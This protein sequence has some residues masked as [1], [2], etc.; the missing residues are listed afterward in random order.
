[1]EDT[2]NN[3]NFHDMDFE[4]INEFCYQKFN[5][6]S[7]DY[8]ILKNILLNKRNNII[9]FNSL[10]KYDRTKN[11]L[12]FYLPGINVNK[13]NIDIP[14]YNNLI[15]I[16]IDKQTQQPEILQLETNK[17]TLQLETLQLETLQPETLQLETLQLET[18]TK[19]QETKQQETKQ[20]ETKQQET[21]QQET[22]QS[23]NLQCVH[24]VQPININPKHKHYEQLLVSL[25][26]TNAIYH[27]TLD[28]KKGVKKTKDELMTTYHNMCENIK[29]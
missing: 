15:D 12:S 1:M 7:K 21:K 23:I 5:N 26:H 9:K 22:R 11:N 18:G 29:N 14:N 2:I 27:V 24:Q 10:K 28:D 6:S 20:Q 4:S 19:Q 25:G 13:Q 8:K 16:N 3:N 17:Q